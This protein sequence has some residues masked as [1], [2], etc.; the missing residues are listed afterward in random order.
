MI[1]SFAV[2]GDFDTA[3]TGASLGPAVAVVVAAA[4]TA[5]TGVG[6]AE[7]AGG[8]GGLSLVAAFKDGCLEIGDDEAVTLARGFRLTMGEVFMLLLLLVC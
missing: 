1:Q 2:T 8:G 4:A 7:A 5:P 6:P 3:A